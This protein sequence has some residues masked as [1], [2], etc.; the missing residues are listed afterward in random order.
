M[1]DQPASGGYSFKYGKT[2]LKNEAT[3]ESYYNIAIL[4]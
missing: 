2:W 3:L 4:I 1:Y